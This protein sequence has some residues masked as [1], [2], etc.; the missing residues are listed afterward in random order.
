MLSNED[1]TI[2]VRPKVTQAEQYG[3][4]HRWDEEKFGNDLGYR[5]R[6]QLLLE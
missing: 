1:L 2:Y 3:D 5:F 6:K 4:G